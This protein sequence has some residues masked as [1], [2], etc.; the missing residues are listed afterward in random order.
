MVANQSAQDRFMGL[1]IRPQR[2]DF[3]CERMIGRKHHEVVTI[4]TDLHRRGI[5]GD[6]PTHRPGCVDTRTS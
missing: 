3:D 4:A 2:P 1:D 6:E 5:L